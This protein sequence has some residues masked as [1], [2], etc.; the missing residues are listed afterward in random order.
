MERN[1]WR[2]FV[3]LMLILIT[4]MQ[5]I[6]PVHAE[7]NGIAC[8]G[9]N[10]LK[11]DVLGNALPGAGFQIAREATKEELMDSSVPKRLLMVGKEALAVVYDA[12]RDNKSMTGKKQTEV[13]TASDGTAA[14]YGLSYGT[15]YLVESKA[16][17]G[18]ERMKSPLRVSI[19]KYSHLTAEDDIRDDDDAVIDNTVHIITIRYSVQE[20]NRIFSAGTALAAMLAFLGIRYGKKRTYQHEI[21]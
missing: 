8:G 9:I 11:T 1:K 15:Y 5:V 3:V 6:F 10:I 2:L 13:T 14:I 21:Q 16:P 12:F 4:M 7:E 18:Y 20:N 17:E 19:N